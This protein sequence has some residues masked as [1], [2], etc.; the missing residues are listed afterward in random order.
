MPN[1][2]SSRSP[3]F[4][5]DKANFHRLSLDGRKVRTRVAY[6][7]AVEADNQLSPKETGSHID[8]RFEMLPPRDDALTLELQNFQCAGCRGSIKKSMFAQNFH[9]C[10]Y[11]GMFCSSWLLSVLNTAICQKPFATCVVPF[12]QT[13]SHRGLNVSA[14]VFCRRGGEFTWIFWG[15]S[16]F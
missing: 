12:L 10:R 4:A 3:S 2:V 5:L 16:F 6:V 11:T 13:I 8:M 15:D 7:K 1:P 14:T 9:Y